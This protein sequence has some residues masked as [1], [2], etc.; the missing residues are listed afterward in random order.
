MCVA[1]IRSCKPI[2]TW[3]SILP[4]FADQCMQVLNWFTMRYKTDRRVWH[5]SSRFTPVLLTSCLWILPTMLEFHLVIWAKFC[6]YDLVPWILCFSCA[7]RYDFPANQLSAVDSCSCFVF[8]PTVFPL[9]P[10][11]KKYYTVWQTSSCFCRLQVWLWH[12]GNNACAS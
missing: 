9:L 12:H 5:M 7:P 11:G 10:V 4:F 2:T 1:T 3:L 6:T 8:F